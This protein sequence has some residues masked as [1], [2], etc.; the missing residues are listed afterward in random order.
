MKEILKGLPNLLT[1]GN[2]ACGA[3][4]I[5][6]MMA[7]DMKSILVFMGIAAVLDFADG[8]VA[9]LLGANGGL[10]K[11]L[12]SL[13]DLITFALL[14]GLIMLH[15]TLE[16]GYCTPDGFCSSR[17][18][19][20]ALPLA[21][22]WRLAN[23]NIDT[24]QKTDFL[25]VPTPITGLAFGSLIFAFENTTDSIFKVLFEHPYFFSFAPIIAACL[26]ISEWP[27]LSLKF[28]K[29][30]PLLYWKASIPLLGL[31]CVP[32]FGVYA[33]IPFLLIYVLWS[34]IANFVTQY[35]Y[36]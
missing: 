23:F 29:G 4:C 22:A 13:A 31:A 1:L 7:D 33:G 34:I 26:M 2:L 8:F 18:A 15:Y 20:L 11:Q 19:W 32:V 6:R 21:G 5:E 25:G 3:I 9:R 10:G 24:R 30:D 12:D 36:G 17:Y 27:M 14:P 28:K 35:K 16:K